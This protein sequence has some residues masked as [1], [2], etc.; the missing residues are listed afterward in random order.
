MHLTKITNS[1]LICYVQINVFNCQDILSE[2]AH[3]EFHSN[4]TVDPFQSMD[5]LAKL[6]KSKAPSG[7][8]VIKSFIAPETMNDQQRVVMSY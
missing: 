4:K 8:K 5:A 1:Y 7:R 3:Q 6:Y 2:L